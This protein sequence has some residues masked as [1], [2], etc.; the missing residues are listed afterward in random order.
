MGL[1]LLLLLLLMW[2]LMLLQ[3]K[4]TLDARKDGIS[5]GRETEKERES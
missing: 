4:I 5:S 1:L 3:E 2:L